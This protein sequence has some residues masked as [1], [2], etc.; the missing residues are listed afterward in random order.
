MNFG[1]C[2]KRIKRL[3]FDFYDNLY[4]CAEMI[5]KDFLFRST[6]FAKKHA[7]IVTKQIMADWD[8]SETNFRT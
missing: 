6:I 1:K 2:C 4:N 5:L 3:P 8:T 7:G